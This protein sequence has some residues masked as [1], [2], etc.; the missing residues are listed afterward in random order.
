MGNCWEQ[1]S[2]IVPLLIAVA[3]GGSCLLELC[4]GVLMNLAPPLV[5]R[6]PCQHSNHVPL[7]V[8][9]EMHG[10]SSQRNQLR[11][12]LG[13]LGHLPSVPGKIG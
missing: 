9:E 3:H 13:S 4:E 8:K 10:P 2:A 5:I 11:T 12:R 1:A 7:P 6:V